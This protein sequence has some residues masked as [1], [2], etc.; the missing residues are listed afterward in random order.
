MRHLSCILPTGCDTCP[1]SI[2]FHTY[3]W[4]NV[5]LKFEPIY[6]LEAINPLRS[7]AGLYNTLPV[8]PSLSCGALQYATC[9]ALNLLRGFTI[10][11]LCRPHSPAGLYNTLPLPPSLSC[12]TLQYAICAA[13]TLLRGFTVRYLCRPHS[14]VGLYNTLPVPPSLSCGAVRAGLGVLLVA[15]VTLPSCLPYPSHLF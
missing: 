2:S 5:E 3:S 9:A 4:R 8:P 6:L 12:E 7:S 11:Y 13:L 14:P 10:R 15:A 1:V